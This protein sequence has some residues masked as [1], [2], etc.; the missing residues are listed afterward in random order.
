VSGPT[1]IYVPAG[2]FYPDGWQLSV[3][4]PEE[5]WECQWD[6]AREILKVSTDPHQQE[7]TITIRQ[8]D[9]DG[10]GLD[11]TLIDQE[12]DGVVEGDGD[13]GC[14]SCGV[15]GGA[16]PSVGQ[17]GIYLLVGLLPLLYAFW[18]KRTVMKS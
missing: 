4:D 5:A 3:S 10:P 8:R 14:G 7:H 15:R 9:P 17:I 6:A 2:R 12:T 11:C 1:E 18:L 16:P 13:D